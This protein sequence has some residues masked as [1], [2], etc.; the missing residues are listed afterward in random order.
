MFIKIIL[1]LVTLVFAHTSFSFLE[2]PYLDPFDYSLNLNTGQYEQEARQWLQEHVEDKSKQALRINPFELQIIA[3]LFYFSYLRS[4]I[5]IHAQKS[6]LS[7]LDQTWQGW[8]AIAQTR[9]NP[10]VSITHT[11]NPTLLISLA[12][13]FAQKEILHRS[14]GRSFAHAAQTAVK[15]SYLSEPLQKA[16]V[17]L[18]ERAR[19]IVIK[20]FL[21]VKETL[22]PLFDIAYKSILD[23]YEDDTHEDLRSKILDTLGHIIPAIAAKSFIEAEKCNIQASKEAWNILFKMNNITA[24][25]WDSIER[26]RAA[27]YAAHYRNI[28]AIINS[29]PIH[30]RYKCILFDENGIKNAVLQNQLLPGTKALQSS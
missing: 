19:T 23:N 11:A 7:L 2:Y 25:V 18:R 5:T 22:G 28:V 16:I 27:Y 9:M 3:N 1:W 12:H 17:A 15:D 20:T 24:Q 4:V 6:A 13:D 26:A 10:S 29:Y 21:D 8:H 14:L 30:D